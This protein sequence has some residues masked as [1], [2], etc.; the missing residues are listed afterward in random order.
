MTTGFRHPTLLLPRDAEAWP[1]E[2]LRVV[3]LHEMAHVKRGDWLTQLLAS[4]ACALYWFNPLAWWARRRLRAEAEQ[5]S[6]DLVLGTGVRPSE[7]ACQLWEIVR[8]LS[9]PHG[10]SGTAVA[11]ARRREIQDRLQA[12]VAA[13]TSRAAL[14]RRAA[15]ASALGALCLLGPVAALRPARMEPDGSQNGAREPASNV[16]ATA[17][18]YAYTFAEGLHLELIA[19][20][21]HRA[22]GGR[23][24]RPNGVLLSGQAVL[25]EVSG[26]RKNLASWKHADHPLAF[27]FRLTSENAEVKGDFVAYLIPPVGGAAPDAHDTWAGH[28]SA[29]P[30]GRADMTYLRAFRQR[31][32]TCS[33]RFGVA[34]GPWQTVATLSY[35]PDRTSV[36]APFDVAFLLWF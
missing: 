15:I 36:G 34:L 3:L 12:I 17:P 9:A 5:A 33:F 29:S 24:W 20:A 19:V 8:G 31:P 7:Y 21:E 1:A 23:S 11:L 28:L 22:D 14:T 35:V 4:L 26:A 16:V 10:L 13:G 27:C 18:G 6:D 30:G 25:P 2:R 32:A